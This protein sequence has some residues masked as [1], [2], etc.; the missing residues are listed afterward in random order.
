[1]FDILYFQKLDQIHHF[2]QKLDIHPQRIYGP[3]FHLV[4]GVDVV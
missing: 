3:V 4:N 2:E 1:M